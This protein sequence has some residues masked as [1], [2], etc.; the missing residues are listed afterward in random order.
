M[1][2]GCIVI[3]VENFAAVLKKKKSQPGTPYA[4][5]LCE[6]VQILNSNLFAQAVSVDRH[7]LGG[8]L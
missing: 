1:L 7:L 6:L 3:Y 5:L 8:P 2:K 4:L